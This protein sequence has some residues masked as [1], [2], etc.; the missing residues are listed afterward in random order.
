MIFMS[1]VEFCH[2]PFFQTAIGTVRKDTHAENF[3]IGLGRRS[4]LIPR[5][6]CLRHYIRRRISRGILIADEGSYVNR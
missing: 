2:G 5:G 4:A 6:I 3:L 1:R